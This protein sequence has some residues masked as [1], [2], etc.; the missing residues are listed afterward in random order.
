ME[1]GSDVIRI[2]RWSPLAFLALF[3]IGTW[4]TLVGIGSRWLKFDESYSHGYMVLAVSLYLSFRKWQDIRPA[5]GF[6]P[7]WL[8]PC[9]LFVAFYLVGSILLIE[10][11]QEFALLPI[12]FCGLLVL[13]GWRQARNFLI[14]I[15]I[16]LF[17]IPIW[18]YLAWYLQLITVAVNQFML[19]WLDIEFI[20]EGVI[21]YFP[22]VGA[23]EIAHGCSG[24]R[25]LLVGLTLTG[26]YSEL[27][28]KRLQ[29]RLWLCLA[30]VMLALIANWIRVF[31]IIYV[32]YESD[33][34]SSLINEHDF[35][36]WWV[37]AGTLVPLFL[38]GRW[39]EG[40]APTEVAAKPVR[41]RKGNAR[42]ATGITIGGT[43]LFA[44]VGWLLEP[45]QDDR[46]VTDSIAHVSPIAGQPQWMP[47]FE[48]ELMGWRPQVDWPDRVFS[49]SFFAP[50]ITPSETA[51]EVRLFLGLYSYDYQRP[52]REI[53]QYNNRLYDPGKFLPTVT[54]TVPVEGSGELAGLALKELGSDSRLYVAY[55]YYVEGRWE[56]NELKAKL[57]QLPGIFN[58]RS[59]ASLLVIG[60]ACNSCDGEER[61][62]ELSPGIKKEAQDYLDRLYE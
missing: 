39:L 45:V 9:V 7:L 26:L 52:R 43:A 62:S 36:G 33:M 42:F 1:R 55:G 40:K 34:T 18:D 60:L 47:L 21:V 41:S 56:T 5:V 35:F 23:F 6:Y 30:G 38:F 25:Y 14:P 19:S 48:N 53:V 58:A 44:V 20:V 3:V 46:S 2:D 57:A 11:F 49:Q 24:L 29:D 8:L 31:V 17:T 12:L 54:F 22:G 59:D 27:N 32:G 51:S 15:G 4:P 37:F 13:W 50:G 61:L 10:A 28:Y 16:L